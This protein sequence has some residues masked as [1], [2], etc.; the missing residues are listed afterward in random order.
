MPRRQRRIGVRHADA[1]IGIELTK[2]LVKNALLR[3]AFWP[4]GRNVARLIGDVAATGTCEGSGRAGML[5][6]MD[7]LSAPRSAQRPRSNVAEQQFIGACSRQPHD[8]RS[9]SA[10]RMRYN[11]ATCGDGG[12]VVRTV[13]PRLSEQ[14]SVYCGIYKSFHNIRSIGSSRDLIY[15]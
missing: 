13:L 1:R 3:R 4:I 12:K 2:T 9:S 5:H 6:S 14:A 10:M 8:R 15:V 7:E 11:A